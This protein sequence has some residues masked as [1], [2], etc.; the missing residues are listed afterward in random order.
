[1]KSKVI[2]WWFSGEQRWR[3]VDT[4]LKK[5]IQSCLLHNCII[6]GVDQNG[7]LGG[8]R[9]EVKIFHRGSAEAAA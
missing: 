9:G 3:G 8:Q 7:F 1:M 6:C 4:V 2:P 5:N